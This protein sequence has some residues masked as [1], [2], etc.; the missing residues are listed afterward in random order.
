MIAA[1]YEE[2]EEEDTEEEQVTNNKKKSNPKQI[3]VDKDYIPENVESPNSESL[4][5]NNRQ[6]LAEIVEQSID[7]DFFQRIDIHHPF[8][9]EERLSSSELIH[10][11]PNLGKPPPPENA[12]IITKRILRQ[13]NQPEEEEIV[14]N[15]EEELHKQEEKYNYD[16]T[17]KEE[18]TKQKGI[19]LDKR[20]GF[21]V[22]RPEKTNIFQIAMH[23]LSIYAIKCKLNPTKVVDQFRK[24]IYDDDESLPFNSSMHLAPPEL[25]KD[26]SHLNDDWRDLGIIAQRLTSI[27]TSE[28]EA[29]RI[30]S[31]QKNVMGQHMTNISPE[32]LKNRLLTSNSEEMDYEIG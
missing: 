7:P 25:W 15:L 28:A 26:V 21:K 31:K 30:I 16:Q 1:Y 18:L 32:T 12:I 27:D 14:D 5:T 29:E 22:F 23:F 8:I 11:H 2:E 20:L 10:D 4:R 3:N 13:F 17:F 6:R 9:P 24:W 19:P